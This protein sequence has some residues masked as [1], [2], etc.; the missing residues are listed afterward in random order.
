MPN[1]GKIVGVDV[2]PGAGPGQVLRCE[3]KD[4]AGGG[5]EIPHVPVGIELQQEIGAVLEKEP[6]VFPA[7]PRGP[8]EFRSAPQEPEAERPEHGRF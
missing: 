8:F 6:D 5:A 2:F 7:R 4:A 3:S 1:A